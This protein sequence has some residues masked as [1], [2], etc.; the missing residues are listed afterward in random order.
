MAQVTVD[1]VSTKNDSDAADQ[2]WTH[3]PVGEPS[4]VTISVSWGAGAGETVSS[5]TYDGVACTLI[6]TASYGA[7]RAAMY[8][9]SSPGSGAKTVR[10]V[11][12]A[13]C[14]HVM[15]CI[16]YLGAHRSSP[17]GTS[18]KSGANG[19][20]A[21]ANVT[22]FGGGLVQDIVTTVEIL[23][24]GAGQTQRWNLTYAVLDSGSSTEP[25]EGTITMSWSIANPDDYAI[26]AV[27]IR[28]SPSGNQAV[29]F[30]IKRM[31]DFM[32]DLRRGLVPPELLKR[33]W[34]QVLRPI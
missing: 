33:R 12:S 3:T 4:L 16:S 6:D 20:T 17:F 15:G 2:S 34:D 1:V 10:V 28:P 30:M 8:Y 11:M 32:R 18:A 19:S 25:G 27:P 13:A 31:Q 22:G 26:L 5:V 9:L 14:S 23:T 29:W 21:N 7:R 24:V